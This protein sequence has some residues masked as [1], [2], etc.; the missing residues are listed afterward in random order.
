MYLDDYTLEKKLGKGAFGEV[1]LTTKKGTSQLFA[2]KKLDKEF[3]ENQTTRKYLLN[4]IYILKELDHPNIVKFADLKKTK[5]HCYIIMEY[6][7]G[8]DLSKALERH[9]EKTG[10]PFPQEL[11]QYF[12]RQ[13][14]SAF[15]YI[16]GKKILHRDIKLE[17]ILI[18]YS[19]NED[20]KNE[21][22]MKATVKIIDFGFAAKMDKNGLKYTTLGSPV[23]MDPLILSELQKRGKKTQKL[24]YDQKA[25]IWSLGT[26]CYEMAIGKNVFD[27]EKLDELIEKVEKGEYTV[28]TALSKELIAFINAMLQ[29][30]PK[31][32][33]NVEQLSKLGF[34]TKNVNEF[35]KMDLQKVK[36]NVVRSKLKLNVKLNQTIWA[37]FNDEDEKTLMNIKEEYNVNDKPI[38]E[39]QNYEYR[40]VYSDA[41]KINNNNTNNNYLCK[42]NS[43]PTKKNIDNNY[44]DSMNPGINNLNFNKKQQIPNN[45]ILQN[46]NINQIQNNIPNTNQR[47]PIQNNVPNPNQ[48]NQIQNKVQ[49]QKQIVQNNAQNQ[50]IP[51]Q[52]NVQ[53]QKHKNL[54]Q[55]NIQNPNIVMNR[56]SLPNYNIA[57]GY[58]PQVYQGNPYGYQVIQQPMVAYP[59]MQVNQGYPMQTGF[60]YGV[61]YYQ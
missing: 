41:N 13:I 2:T 33:L 12:M 40:R 29:Y 38:A 54:I 32:R 47:N 1:Y 57:Y 48:K 46:N 7:N 36:K 59:Q 19:S 43:L 58:T 21:N 35:Q 31:Q 51:I 20:K 22:L 60:V 15:K 6:C 28:P 16:H 44:S 45:N 39:D 9:I 18:N 56:G 24:G 10:K 42:R 30:D 25:D 4:E 52:N 3:F 49:N 26:V 11:V 14:I 37:V 8:G 5:N 61:Q 17:N 53:N 50:K 55:N 34:L 23:N 27:A